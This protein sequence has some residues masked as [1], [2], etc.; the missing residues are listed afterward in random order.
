MNDQ[1]M[2]DAVLAGERIDGVT[3]YWDSSDPQN[4]GPAYRIERADGRSA[5]GSLNFGCWSADGCDGYQLE[6]YFDG[7]GA[8]RGPDADGVY[9][10]M[11]I[12]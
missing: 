5:S 12:E 7:N 2:I 3:I 10:E 9:P 4:V 11:I 8:Y 1:D 6:D